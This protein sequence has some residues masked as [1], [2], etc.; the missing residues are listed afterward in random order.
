MVLIILFNLL[1]VKGQN[2]LC[3]GKIFL[4]YF[5]HYKNNAESLK[6]AKLNKKLYKQLIFPAL[7]IIPLLHTH[8]C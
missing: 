4:L 8:Q 7:S 2:I 3:S 6:K 1:I 5:L